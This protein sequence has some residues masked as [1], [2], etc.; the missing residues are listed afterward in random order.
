M[1]VTRGNIHIL[2]IQLSINFLILIDLI[3]YKLYNLCSSICS[4]RNKMS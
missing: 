1:G 4:I 3:L 2:S